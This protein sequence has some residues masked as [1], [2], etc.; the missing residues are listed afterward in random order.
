MTNLPTG[1]STIWVRLYTRNGTGWHFNDYSYT[2]AT[3]TLAVLTSPTP[4]STLTGASATFV[5]S[6]GVGA[7]EYSLFVGTTPGG[8]RPLHQLP[9]AEHLRTR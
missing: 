6:S 7:L 1:G 2:A 5:W 3:T 8:Q 9:G 4:S